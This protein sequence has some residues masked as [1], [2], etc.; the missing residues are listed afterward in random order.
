MVITTHEVIH[1]MEKSKIPGMALKL[2]ISKAYD[3]VRW[4]FLFSIIARLG[5]S[6]QVSRIIKNVVTFVTFSVLV[7]GTLGNF[8]SFSQ[9]LH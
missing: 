1:S 2:D 7:N 9:G 8:F 5:F 3:K 4:D 6:E